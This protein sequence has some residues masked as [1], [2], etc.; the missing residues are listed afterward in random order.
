MAVG[1]SPAAANAILDA[2]HDTNYPWVQLHT[3]DPGAAGTANV[4]GNATRKDMS[5]AWSPASGG[6]KTNDVAVEWTD[7]EVD[8]S[9]DYT[10]V[11]YWS[12][13]SGGTFG[14]SGTMTANA[15]SDT[16][17][18]FSILAGG[19]TASFNTAA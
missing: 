12:A 18:A 8:T 16:G 17:D 19:V 10:H 5:A 11:S 9:E 6:S 14:G 13:S 4:A 15:V 2:H 7:A 1:L 3:G